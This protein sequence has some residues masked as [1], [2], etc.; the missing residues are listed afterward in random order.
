[1]EARGSED[2]PSGFGFVHRGI[3]AEFRPHF[4]LGRRFHRLHD[5]LYPSAHLLHE[6]GRLQRANMATDVIS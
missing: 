3:G 6:T 5:D 2:R 1:M 4:G